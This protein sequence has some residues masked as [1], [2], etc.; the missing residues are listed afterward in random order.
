MPKVFIIIINFNG[1]PDTRECLA[2]LEKLDYDNF[3]VVLIDNG[4]RDGNR[5][6]AIGSQQF[7]IRF[8][9][10]KENLGFAA[11][12]N[13]G[14]KIALEQNTDYV[15]FLN[16]DTTVKPDF[17]TKLVEAAQ[18]DKK[19]GIVG[20]VIYHYGEPEKIQFAGGK[21]NWLRTRGEHLTVINA[22]QPPLKLKPVPHLMREGGVGE[23][24]PVDYITGCSLLAKREVI[25]K[26]GFLNEDYFLYYEDV[27]WC[28]RA[29]KAGF[30][31][32]LASE[33]KIYH[34]QSSSAGE[35]SYPDIYY[36]TRNGLICGWRHG[37]KIF[38]LIQS[39]WIF[40]KQI[41]KIIIGYKRNWARPV[42]KG[43]IDFWRGKREKLEGYY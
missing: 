1:W 34:K 19:I 15:L 11:G 40:L 30:D 14:I 26:I 33:A 16:N 38:V 4:S 18:S 31:C 17:L 32:V 43:I 21:V 6:S 41:V 36:H 42:M 3:E 9:Q 29:Q 13:Q 8:I 22:P 20:S 12:N 25:E 10:N 7:K 27:D 23:L 5:Q 28:L 35:F 2:S 39:V 24:Y 37:P